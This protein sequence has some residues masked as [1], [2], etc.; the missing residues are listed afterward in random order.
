M[1]EHFPDCLAGRVN[2]LSY[3]GLPD[4]ELI[5]E[6]SVGLSGGQESVKSSIV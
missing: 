5:V 3:C 6:T 2:D 1:M 4:S